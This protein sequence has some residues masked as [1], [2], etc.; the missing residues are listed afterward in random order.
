MNDRELKIERVVEVQAELLWKCWTEPKH[1][2]PWFT[3]KPWQTIDAKCELVAGGE[4]YTLMKSPE[5]EQF[6][7]HGIYLEL[8]KNKRIVWTD[9]ILKGWIPTEDS[10]DRP[11]R[12]IFQLDFEDIG[13]GKSKFTGTARHWNIEECKKH[14]EMGFHE[15]W[16]TA[17]DQLIEYSKTIK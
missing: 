16:G 8:I 17:L 3:P 1:L 15:G 14:A 11:F 12:G 7:N 10:S 6:S 13:N 5:G 2:I 9:A 4:F